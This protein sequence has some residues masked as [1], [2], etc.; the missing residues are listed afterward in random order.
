MLQ[1][2]WLTFLVFLTAWCILIN[3]NSI[4]KM[5]LKWMDNVIVIVIMN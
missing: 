1:S 5:I 4:Q 3:K 2:A